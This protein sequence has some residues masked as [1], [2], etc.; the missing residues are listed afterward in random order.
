MPDQVKIK[1]WEQTT[2]EHKTGNNC[3][4]QIRFGGDTWLI[5]VAGRKRT[6]GWGGGGGGGERTERQKGKLGA[7]KGLVE[8]T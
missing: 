8:N 5:G 1:K 6:G 4:Q 7:G 2:M 3:I